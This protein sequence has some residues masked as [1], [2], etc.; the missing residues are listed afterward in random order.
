MG[1]VKNVHAE[2]E[3]MDGRKET[4]DFSDWHEYSKYL[5]GHCGEI[6][7]AHGEMEREETVHER[8]VTG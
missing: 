1:N 2:I 7:N 8:L 3:F 5:D 4:I 6:E